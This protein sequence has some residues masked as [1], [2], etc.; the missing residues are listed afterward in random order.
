MTYQFRDGTPYDGP[1]VTL[2][3]GRVMSGATFTPDSKPVIDMGKL[4]SIPANEFVK[5]EVDDG[6]E[7]SGELHEAS[8]KKAS[9]QSGK[10]RGKG[11]KTGS[12]VSKK[13]AKAG[14]SV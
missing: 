13:S 7:R 3:D 6:S 4:K 5:I 14:P 1:V 11:R 9:V 10:T 2:P 12:V 8:P